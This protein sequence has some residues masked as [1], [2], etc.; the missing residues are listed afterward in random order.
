MVLRDDHFSTAT[1]AQGVAKS[2]A[3]RLGKTQSEVIR[4]AVDRLIDR[5]GSASRLDLLRSARGLWSGRL[6]LPDADALRREWD[7]LEAGVD[8]S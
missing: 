4:A 7:R 2:I 8:G 1:F 3:R 6:D 5:E